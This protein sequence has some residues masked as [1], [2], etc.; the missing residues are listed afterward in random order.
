LV[1]QWIWTSKTDGYG[2][3][4]WLGEEGVIDFAGSGVVHLL[5]ATAAI[6]AAYLV[7]PRI[8]R[9]VKMDGLTVVRTI[10]PY[11]PILCTIGTWILIFGWLSFNA[12]SS[13]GGDLASLT[14]SARA[15]VM[16]LIALGAGGV[17]CTLCQLPGG[18][19]DLL[20]LN[21]G[22]LGSLV[23]ITAGCA[24]MDSIG[25]FITG[26]IGGI[27]SLH[28]HKIPLYFEIDDPLDTFT[29]HGL[30]GAWGLISLGFF[31]TK[32]FSDGGNYGIL[33]GGSGELL[34]W[35]I[36]ATLA[37][38][39]VGA[40][41]A[42]VSL[43]LISLVLTTCGV[44][45]NPLRIPETHEKVGLDENEFTGYAFPEQKE[46]R[47]IADMAMRASTPVEGGSCASEAIEVVDTVV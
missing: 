11:D 34:G 21:N 35:Q 2:G 42:F 4:G 47:D 32:N 31:A 38:I 19:L 26:F 41:V 36:V 43:S 13:G 7:G 14:I 27:I 28:G 24:N 5:G 46:L 45:G 17:S 44:E 3:S 30:N 33:Y 8:G 1:A 15:V 29:V 40:T 25:S 39:A 18:Q 9:F 6:V 12:S 16:T 20:A 10:P 22:L 37:I 23:A